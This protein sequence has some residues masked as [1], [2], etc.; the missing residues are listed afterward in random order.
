MNLRRASMGMLAVVLV[1]MASLAVVAH[2]AEEGNASSGVPMPVIPM[3]LGD[4]C[5]KDTDFMRRNHMD[6]LKHQRDETMLKG[7]RVEQYSLKECISCHAVNGPDSMPVTV[8]SPQHFCRSCH[9]Y[10][11]VSIDCFQCH[12]SRP[13]SGE[14]QLSSTFPT[15]TTV[16]GSQ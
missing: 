4:S 15:T 12:A 11:A 13:E 14:H 10:A 9:D 5:V 2:A 8:A 3:G 7:I 1:Y 6:M 16:H